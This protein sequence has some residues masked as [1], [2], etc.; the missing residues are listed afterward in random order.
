MHEQGVNIGE[1]K[2]AFLD[3]DGVINVDFGYVSSKQK[4]KL[5]D[6]FIE[7]VNYLIQNNFIIVVI[8]NQSGIARSY[9]T[10]KTFRNFSNWIYLY[11][12]ELNIS[13]KSTYYCPH[14]PLFS[15]WCDCR[16]PSPK[17]IIQALNDFHASP[18]NCLFIGDKDTDIEAASAAKICRLHK[19]VSDEK[20]SITQNYSIGNW[21]YFLDI[22]RGKHQACI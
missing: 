9:Y 4:F 14:H 21:K 7:G 22:E 2:I 18:E 16:K 6:G 11:L 17:M 5:V 3:R 10:E 20:I 13:I 19:L 12:K 8:T 1:T 15:G